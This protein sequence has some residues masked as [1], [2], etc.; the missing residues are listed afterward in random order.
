MKSR[1]LHL[2]I[3][4]VAIVAFGWIT[5]NYLFGIVQMPDDSMYPKVMAGDVLLY[6]RMESGYHINDVVSTTVEGTEYILRVVAQGGD[7]VDFSEDG[8]LI[9]NDQIQYEEITQES[10]AIE[11]A[12]MSY[13]YQ[14]PA[15]SYFLLADA[16]TDGI[17]SRIF[18]ARTIK[19]I[20]GKVIGSFRHRQF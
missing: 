16:R 20:N 10:Y 2:L 19:Q 6:S 17:D 18:G 7:T 12:E 13:P 9:V 15:G 1:L 5:L 8:F 11:D 4:I 14:V 3:E